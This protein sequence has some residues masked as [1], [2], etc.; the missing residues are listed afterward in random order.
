MFHTSGQERVLPA[1]P[2]HIGFTGGT[3]G[4][5]TCASCKYKIYVLHNSNCLVR[6]HI[7]CIQVDRT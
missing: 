2:N 1:F 5:P 7:L 6:C 4:I 3:G